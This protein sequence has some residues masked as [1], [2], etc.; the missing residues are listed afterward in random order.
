MNTK[1]MRRVIADNVTEEQRTNKGAK[2]I[3]AFA[4]QQGLKLSQGDIANAVQFVREYIEHVPQVIEM[5]E[6]AARNRG[7][8]AE[9]RQFLQPAEHYWSEP[10]DVLPDHHGLF[11]LLD[12]A[13]VFLSVVQTMS[14]NYQ[15]QTGQPLLSLDLS[16]ANLNARH[17]IGEP[18]AT[19]LDM[20]V[21][22]IM[23][24]P[25]VQ[26]LYQLMAQWGA[27]MQNLDVPDPLWGNASI[28]DIVNARLGA[29]GVV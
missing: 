7:L 23:N 12:D 28:N 20:Q 10:H 11:G 19:Q 26:N 27:R 25:M 8:L 16:L 15:A 22:Q 5:T 29:L 4:L 2:G 24:G 13:Y 3:R 18:F 9:A 6:S 21:Q 17:L 14:M 1:Q